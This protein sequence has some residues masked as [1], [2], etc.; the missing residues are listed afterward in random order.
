MGMI[1]FLKTMITPSLILDFVIIVVVFGLGSFLFWKWFSKKFLYT[2][3]FILLDT[4]GNFNEQ[5]AK[6]IKNKQAEK[7][8]ELKDY[9]NKWLDVLESNGNFN[10]RPVRFVAFD[11]LGNLAY[12]EPITKDNMDKTNY[13]KT[14]LQ[15]QE[16]ESLANTVIESSEKYR[17]IDI[18][19]KVAIGLS[20]ILIMFL[21]ISVYFV[22]KFNFKIAEEG[23]KTASTLNTLADKNIK[24]IEVIERNTIMLENILKFSNYSIELETT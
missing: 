5:K 13:M 16:R 8:F 2:F 24:T 19:S 21:L 7:K 3:D 17:G 10:N 12:C 4:R 20:V 14:A 11:G 18:A 1:D 9:P 6:I 22:G 15:P 23:S